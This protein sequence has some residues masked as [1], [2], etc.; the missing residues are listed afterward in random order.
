LPAQRSSTPAAGRGSSPRAV[1]RALLRWYRRH[2]RDLPWRHTRDP[3]RVWVSEIML[4]QTRVTAALPYYE[5]FLERFP[6]VQAL[7]AA[8]EE[9]LL[10]AWSGLGYYRRVRQ[11]QAAARKICAEHGGVFPREFEAIRALPGV[12]DYTAAAVASI[13][14]GQAQAV[15]DGNVARV[16]ARLGDEAEDVRTAAV[17][18]R[19]RERAQGLVEAAGPGQ[20]GDLNQALMELGATLCS[21]R[22]PQCLLCPLS[23]ACESRR[24]GV[25]EQRPLKS[26]PARSEKLE[27]A[28]ALVKKNGALLLRQRPADAGVMP[29]FWELPQAQGER[30]GDN[31]FE[32]LGVE[33]GEPLG[34]F[35][36]GITFRA[37]S[38][39]VYRG[40]AA[41][42]PRGF[43]WVKLGELA[44][45]PLTTITR[46]ALAAAGEKH[47]NP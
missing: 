12:G 29:R 45:L 33:R 42:K 34:T 4:Q 21:P 18:R 19:L 30:L 20:H 28:V 16:L 6:D 38:G 26:A 23:G 8:P 32:P 43:R 47:P 39:T 46:K 5:R 25:Q 13:C 11:M 2:R 37:Y 15:L 27:L 7:A 40:R 10:E 44:A 31:P 1:S 17:R 36:H 35:T 3:Y 14:F 41:R 24:R 9:R 22:G